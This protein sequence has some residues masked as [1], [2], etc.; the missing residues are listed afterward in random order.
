MKLELLLIIIPVRNRK[1]FTRECLLSL[2]NQTMKSFR[3]IVI[4]D[5]STDGTGEMIKMEFPEVI[6]LK[7]DGNLWWTKATNLGVKYALEKG[8]DYILTLNDDTVA[9][10]DYIEK[11]IYWAEIKKNVLLGSFAFDFDTKKPVYGGE[12]INWKRAKSD[13]LLDSLK[14]DEFSGLYKVSLYPG[15]G[16][17]IPAKVFSDIGLYDEKNFPHYYA[18]ID[19]A[20]RASSKGFEIFCNYDSKL[21]VRIEESRD[22]Q[23]RKNKS[24]KSYFL[25]L[26]GK[27][28]G[29]NL[30]DFFIYGLKNCP[31][32]YLPSFLIVGSIKRIFGYLLEWLNDKRFGLYIPFL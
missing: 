17:L 21:F 24:F 13:F 18:D 15:R 22:Y 10:E 20:L 26:F 11:M 32:K 7:G 19:F 28:G 30:K 6:L 16:L 12:I 5:G 31:L 3:I 2:K 27:H 29:G 25:H 4:D 8:A 9:A 1:I 23:L 14:P